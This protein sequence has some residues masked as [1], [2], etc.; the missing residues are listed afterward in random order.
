MTWT[1]GG[2]PSAN[3]RDEVRF[4]SGDTDTTDQLVTDEEI[5]YAVAET[6]DNKLAA[7][8]ICEA[9]AAEFARYVDHVNGPAAEKA[10]QRVK[11][12]ETKAAKLRRQ[13]GG[14][15]KPLFGG[16]S[17]A[18]KDTL[19]SDTDVPQPFFY[20]SRTDS[21]GASSFIFGGGSNDENDT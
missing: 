10:S 5:A 20:R 4:L 9:L 15:A 11:H 1:Y 19:N 14:A 7:A 16:Q 2:D 3:N 18:D 6:S 8:I 13:A 21:P 17:L 12:Y